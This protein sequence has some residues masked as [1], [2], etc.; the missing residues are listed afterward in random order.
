MTTDINININ[1]KYIELVKIRTKHI[2][3][4]ALFTEMYWTKIG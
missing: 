3:K 1:L 2:F 4:I